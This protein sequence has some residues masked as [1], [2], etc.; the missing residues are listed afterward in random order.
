MICCYFISFGA[1]LGNTGT[2]TPVGESVD[3]LVKT[4]DNSPHNRLPLPHHGDQG[5][6]GFTLYVDL[7]VIAN[8]RH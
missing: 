2:I 3:P 7:R 1:L 4:I 8:V 6:E 5:T